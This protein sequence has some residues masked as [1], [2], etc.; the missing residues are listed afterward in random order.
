[1]DVGGFNCGKNGGL[2]LEVV[3]YMRIIVMSKH[4]KML[5]NSISSEILF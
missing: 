2:Q 1:M 3:V 5:Q 4:K